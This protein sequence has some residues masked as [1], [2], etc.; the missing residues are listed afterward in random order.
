METKSGVDIP[1]SSARHFNFIRRRHIWIVPVLPFRGFDRLLQGSG[2][3]GT[4][5][6]FIL[7]PGYR[8]LDDV[9]Y[10]GIHLRPVGG[11]GTAGDDEGDEEN[12]E[13]P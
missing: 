7:R 3:A 10:V 2:H 6:P 5:Q 11:G 13:F 1:S 4:C 9:I 8:R 12:Q